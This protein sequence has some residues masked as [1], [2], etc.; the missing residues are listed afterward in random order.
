MRKFSKSASAHVPGTTRARERAVHRQVPVDRALRKYIA[1]SNIGGGPAYGVLC[2]SE[3][4]L[5]G[6]VRCE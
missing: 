2:E 4:R 5:D 1:I 6:G 3:V